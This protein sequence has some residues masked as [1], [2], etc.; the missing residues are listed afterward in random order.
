MHFWFK[1]RVE[2]WKWR[3]KCGATQSSVT[4]YDNSSHILKYS[5]PAKPMVTPWLIYTGN[6]TLFNG[7]S[8]YN[9]KANTP[10][11]CKSIQCSNCLQLPTESYAV[12]ASHRE[13]PLRPGHGQAFNTFLGGEVRGGVSESGAQCPK[14]G[15]QDFWL[16][17]HGNLS[18][19]HRPGRQER[20]LPTCR[21]SL[22]GVQIPHDIHA[23]KEEWT[24]CQ[25][26]IWKKNA[27]CDFPGK[28]TNICT[29]SPPK[30]M[31]NGWC[32]FPKHSISSPQNSPI[33]LCCCWPSLIWN[34]AWIHQSAKVA[35]A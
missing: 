19:L 32:F 4:Q 29:Q 10:W 16:P 6:A 24:K 15:Q 1:Q 27:P 30:K 7:G 18:I 22:T 14:S 26:V 21:P 34:I 11:W 28:I 3:S 5:H 12:L 35:I 8:L 13:Y 33:L 31:K 25:H 17:A 20:R 2:S 9:S 23:E